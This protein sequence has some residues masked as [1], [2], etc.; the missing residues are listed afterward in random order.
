MASVDNIVTRILVEAQQKGVDAATASVANLK[1]NINELNQLQ[2]IQADQQL[3]GRAGVR[4]YQSAMNGLGMAFKNE[5]KNMRM[6]VRN[7]NTVQK[8]LNNTNRVGQTTRTTL[9]NLADGQTKLQS[10][11]QS[12]LTSYQKLRVML[13]TTRQGLVSLSETWQNHMKNMQWTGRQLMV[14]ITLPLYAAGS[15]ALRTFTSIEEEF[16]RLQK[17]LTDKEAAEIGLGIGQGFEAAQGSITTTGKIAAGTSYE[18]VTNFGNVRQA[19]DDLAVAYGVQQSIVTAVAADWAAAGYAGEQLIPIVDEVFRVAALGEVDVSVATKG[20]TQLINV[21]GNEFPTLE[22]KVRNASNIINQ[23]NAIENSTVL[24]MRELIDAFPQVATN[25]N[26]FGLSA[27]ET[28]AALVA[29]KSA[30]IDANEGA[31]ALKFGLQRMINPTNQAVEA[32]QDIKAEYGDIGDVFL[33]VMDG[34][35]RGQEAL[36]QFSIAFM[37]LTRQDEITAQ[38]FLGTLVQ[39]R[40]ASRLGVMYQQ[41]AAGVLEYRDSVDESGVSTK[42]AESAQNQWLKAMLASGQEGEKAVRKLN[43]ELSD[44][45]A[46]ELELRL[47]D[48]IVQIGRL[49]AQLTALAHDFIRAMWPTL[50]KAMDKI[51]EWIEKFR[52][53]SDEAKQMIGKV[54]AGF[55]ALGPVIFALAQVGLALSTVFHWVAKLI[56][57]VKFFSSGMG[58][59]ASNSELASKGVFN[60]GDAF[61]YVRGQ[62]SDVIGSVNK[63]KTEQKALNELVEGFTSADLARARG[64]FFSDVFTRPGAAGALAASAMEGGETAGLILPRAYKETLQK[65]MPKT[66]FWRVL[67]SPLEG[68]F[69][70]IGKPFQP[71]INRFKDFGSRV[72]NAKSKMEALTDQ[73]L[74]WFGRL[75]KAMKRNTDQAGLFAGMFRGIGGRFKAF[76]DAAKNAWT[77]SRQGANRTN[78]AIAAISQ[79]FSAMG[80]SAASGGAQSGTALAGMGVS[81]GALA[82]VIAVI[83]AVVAIVIAAFFALREHWDTIYAAMKP[84]IDAIKKGWERLKEAAGGVV[85][86]FR[87]IFG[88]FDEGKNKGEGFAAAMGTMVGQVLKFFGKLLEAV[89]WVIDFLKPFWEWIARAVRNVIGVL[90]ALF[91]GEWSTAWAYAVRLVYDLFGR[92]IMVLLDAVVDFILDG[93]QVILDA[94]ASVV[95]GISDFIGFF[96]GGDPM[97]GWE[98]SIRGAAD[99]VQEFGDDVQMQEWLEDQLPE[100]DNQA[101]LDG[102]EEDLDEAEDEARDGGEDVGDGLR[103]GFQEGAPDRQDVSDALG[104]W[105]G[106]LKST[107][108]E[109]IDKMKQDAMDALEEAHEARLAIFDERIEAI[110]EMEKKEQELYDTE[111]YLNRKRQTRRDFALEVEN[112]KR[113]RAL[114][115][116]EG[117]IDDARQ[118]DSEMLV[119]SREHKEN[120]AK[121]EEDRRRDLLQ[122]ERDEQKERIRTR[123][124][125]LRQILQDEKDAFKERLDMLTRYTPRNIAQVKAL[126]DGV[127]SLLGEYGV[128][129]WSSAYKNAVNTWSTATRLARSDLEDQ[130]YWSGESAGEEF[131]AGVE[132]SAPNQGNDRQGRRPVWERNRR[133]GRTFENYA[134]ALLNNRREAAQAAWSFIQEQDWERPWRRYKA[135]LDR[136]LS[137]AGGSGSGSSSATNQPSFHYHSGGTVPGQMPRDIPATLQSGEYVIQ[138]NAAK[139]LG[140][141]ALDWLNQAHTYHSGG[142]AGHRH[143]GQHRASPGP[144]RPFLGANE[145]MGF[146]GIFNQMVDN[147]LG[148]GGGTIG[149]KTLEEFQNMFMVM[150][151]DWSGELFAGVPGGHL[152]SNLT[153]LLLE[154]FAAQGLRMSSLLRPGAVTASGR[155]SDHGFGRAVDLAAPMT[156]AGIALMRRV[157]EYVV[158]NAAA[159]NLKQAIFQHDLWT[160]GRLIRGGYGPTDHFDHVH[161]AVWK[162]L[163]RQVGGGTVGGYGGGPVKAYVK[164][165]MARFGWGPEHWPALDKLIQGESSWNPTIQNRSSG[166]FGLFQFMPF[167][168]GPGRILPHGTRSNIAQQVQAGFSYIKGKYGTPTGAYNFW[169]RTDPRPYPGHWY[170][171]GGG[172]AMMKRGGIVPWNNFPAMLHKG[173]AVLPSQL[174]NAL[175]AVAS[176]RY[177]TPAGAS[178]LGITPGGGGEINAFGGGGDTYIHVDTFIGEEQWFAEMK[179]KY[180]MKTGLAKQRKRGT[181][182]RRVSSRMDNTVRFR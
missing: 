101:F 114:A 80:A 64:D 157:F 182:N 159:F 140:G 94:V 17:V 120:M 75:R 30:G 76:K 175:S 32:A 149:G 138:R 130:A 112:Y 57:S 155:P 161:I 44:A 91:S 40:Q 26:L 147:F 104:E 13:H 66:S 11:T 98:E 106:A 158:Q 142:P 53:L 136:Y 20:L 145:N 89:A 123:Q 43:E 124:E 170:H 110:E 45:A 47:D 100:P 137:G 109:L 77:E 60:I 79:G 90:A 96:T 129:Q 35:V 8:S 141:K 37:E 69:K 113:A 14:G 108:D 163:E 46:R 146:G 16:T 4:Q 28:A 55:A 9:N 67:F 82:A 7:V 6:F 172:P 59:L 180:D 70:V 84:G 168:W 52:N 78:S 151:V 18:M 165:Q 118:L 5:A 42:T 23:F 62:I 81:A 177:M 63:Y 116:Y 51:A 148:G 97:G 86:I 87:D 127:S 121:I 139:R 15:A 125:A 10:T 49:R 56:P 162:A 143:P 27:S 12:A 167:H 144:W 115:I 169:L 153:S 74:G 122:K 166:A 85:Q 36:N 150:L 68:F 128:R 107:L 171:G 173:E 58:N 39:K 134:D 34:A 54:L 50:Q 31:H 133:M 83:A 117:R 29:M 71:L 41:M 111:E 102:I 24:Q 156:T 119:T 174:T 131:A 135:Q 99:A 105:R 103:E 72:W 1:K 178:M 33:N 2:R 61:G 126:V 181:L 176:K 93:F 92:P 48:P 132:G 154:R 3:K 65:N 19:V 22:G 38:R 160:D 164:S 21:F 25:A 88:E 73:D 179:S 152:V 95:G